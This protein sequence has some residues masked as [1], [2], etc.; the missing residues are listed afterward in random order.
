MPYIKPV[1]K[2]VL[3]PLVERLAER[4]YN[5]GDLTY[6]IYALAMK[7]SAAL[8]KNYKNLSG[9]I[10]CMDCAKTEFYRRIVAPYEDQKIEE[11]GDV[12]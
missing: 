6:V 10:G 9:L 1:R 5:A 11:N 12:E 2:E 3:E 8:G 4:C 7:M